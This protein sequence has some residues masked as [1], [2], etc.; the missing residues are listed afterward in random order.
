MP[1]LHSSRIIQDFCPPKEISEEQNGKKNQDL[2]EPPVQNN[3]VPCFRCIP[4]TKC[5]SFMHFCIIV[6]TQISKHTFLWTRE[7][8][9][10]AGER[11]IEYRGP[12]PNLMNWL[13]GVYSEP[14][15]D[16]LKPT[17]DM[18]HNFQQLNFCQ[19]EVH[20]VKLYSVHDK[21]KG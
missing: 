1:K 3:N 12:T 8:R 5:Y 15:Y 7:T 17:L 21:F 4:K 16:D 18:P 10:I 9:Y 11:D 6:T 19:N 20:G 2:F 14:T 13:E